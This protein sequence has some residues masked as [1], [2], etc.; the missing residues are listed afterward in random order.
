MKHA[1]YGR[2][3]S[4]RI[5]ENRM[6]NSFEINFVDQRDVHKYLNR[7]DF[8][9]LRNLIEFK[10][11]DKVVYDDPSDSKVIIVTIITIYLWQVS[12]T[13]KSLLRIIL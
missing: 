6:Q 11:G 1:F 12:I 3:S 13:G 10:K 2:T 9:D 4:I 8:Q 7:E 5:V